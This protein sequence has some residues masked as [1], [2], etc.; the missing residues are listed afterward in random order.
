MIEWMFI[1]GREFF[2]FSIIL[3]SLKKP[4]TS[5]SGIFLM[6]CFDFRRS[7][8]NTLNN[9]FWLIIDV[10]CC[11]VLLPVATHLH[12]AVVTVNAEYNKIKKYLSCDEKWPWSHIKWRILASFENIRNVYQIYRI[13]SYWDTRKFF[14]ACLLHIQNEDLKPRIFTS[15]K[16]LNLLCY[17][18][19]L[20]CLTL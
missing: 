3:I 1:M 17:L 11:F 14:F 10:A 16:L 6:I 8:L 13:Q 2:N 20:Y 9:S 5:H 18:W 12:F 19:N 7:T 4:T 15:W